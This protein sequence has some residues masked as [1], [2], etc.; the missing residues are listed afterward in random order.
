M[1]H[2]ARIINEWDPIG[3]F[4]Y[5]PVDEYHSEIAEIK[6]LLSISKTPEELANG[7]YAIFCGSFGKNIFDKSKEECLSIALKLI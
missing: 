3:L 1:D 7:I 4:P 2:I 5:A 6:H